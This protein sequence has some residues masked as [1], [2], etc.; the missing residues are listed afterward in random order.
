MLEYIFQQAPLQGTT[1]MEPLLA[2]GVGAAETCTD[3]TL[4]LLRTKITVVVPTLGWDRPHVE[5]LHSFDIFNT[6]FR[7]PDC[8]SHMDPSGT[9]IVGGWEF[10]E[11]S[12]RLWTE[13]TLLVDDGNYFGR[14]GN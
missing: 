3:C 2:L 12:T 10:F 8:T 9:M 7:Y 5:P 11:S 14:L 13:N 1:H 4:G 6:D